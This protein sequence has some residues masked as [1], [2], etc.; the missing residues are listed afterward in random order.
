MTRSDAKVP[1]LYDARHFHLR[2]EYTHYIFSLTVIFVVKHGGLRGY[3]RLCCFLRQQS[4]T[5]CRPH[6]IACSHVYGD[7]SRTVWLHG[8]RFCVRLRSFILCHLHI[9]A[10]FS[11]SET[12]RGLHDYAGLCFCLCL[13]SLTLLYYV[14]DFRILQGVFNL[15]KFTISSLLFFTLVWKY[16]QQKMKRH[17]LLFVMLKYLVTILLT[18]LALINRSL[19]YYLTCF[20]VVL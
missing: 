11:S 1:S 19:V 4:F 17:T 7:K 14:N 9:V 18:L 12:S 13:H 5:L 6:F 10:C 2:L 8:H 3:M 20:L 15:F 16:G